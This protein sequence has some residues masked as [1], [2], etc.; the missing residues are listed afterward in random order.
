MLQHALFAAICPCLRY[1]ACARC[2]LP[3]M[4]MPVEDGVELGID[5]LADHPLLGVTV[6]DPLNRM[7]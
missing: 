6:T 7:R 1:V 4:Q 5:P 2:V 3:D